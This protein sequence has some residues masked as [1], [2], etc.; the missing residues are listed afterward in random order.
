MGDPPELLLTVSQI[1]GDDEREVILATTD[2]TLIA[3]FT[4]QLAVRLGRQPSRPAPGPRALRP[5]PSEK[6]DGGGGQR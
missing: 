5:I 4:D 6:P 2:P 1:T 3:A